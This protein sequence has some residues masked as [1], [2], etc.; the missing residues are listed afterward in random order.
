V[1]GLDL[2]GSFVAAVELAGASVARAASAELP[3]GLIVDGEVRDAAGLG[4]VLGPFFKAH[5]LS[6]S[7]RLGVANQQIVVRQLELPRIDDPREQAAAVRFQSAEAIAMP[8]DEAVLDFQPVGE[9]VAPDGAVRTRFV[10]VAARAAMIESWVEAVRGAGLKPLGIDLS[11]FALL[12]AL[13][14]ADATEAARVHCHLGGVT[15]LAVA[16][17]ASCLFTRPLAAQSLDARAAAPPPPP[18]PE[19]APY[20][21]PASAP[22]PASPAPA[23]GV[24]RAV[25][26]LAE[27]IRLSIDFYMAQPDARW[28]SEV[29]LSG[30][31][32]L[33]PR[34]VEELHQAL[35]LPVSL[36]EPLGAL[37]ALGLPPDEDPHRHT[38][39]AGLA[40]GA[41]A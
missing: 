8:L 26:A 16:V 15:N 7:V 22:G 6:R 29:V 20:Y 33:R 12:R 1:V 10:V 36:A 21:S 34:L 27:E 5:G 31:G 37:G 24:G 18:P 14:P 2:D 30:P 23:A 38:V 32:A 19:S 13:T 25:A 17:G 11:A 41:G 3:P 9:T 28:V 39:A 4:A 40:L 35:S